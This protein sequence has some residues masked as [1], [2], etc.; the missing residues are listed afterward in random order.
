METAGTR[1]VEEGPRAVAGD[2]PPERAGAEAAPAGVPPG[3][4]A[5]RGSPGRGAREAGEVPDLAPADHGQHPPDPRQRAEELEFRRWRTRRAQPVREREERGGHDLAVRA[6][7]RRRV[8]AVRRE[9]GEHR[10][11]PRAAPPPEHVGGTLK[12]EPGPWPGGPGS[13]S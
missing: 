4:G 2:G 3:R 1:R 7:P 13:A 5:G 9:E 6:E 12:P 8:P 10:V 11:E